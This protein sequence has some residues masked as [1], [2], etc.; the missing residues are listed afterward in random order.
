MFLFPYASTLDLQNSPFYFSGI[1][2]EQG[3]NGGLDFSLLKDVADLEVT[4]KTTPEV[5]T[6]YGKTEVLP[7]NA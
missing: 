1:E 6:D 7:G 4:Y 3:E 2:E 5:E